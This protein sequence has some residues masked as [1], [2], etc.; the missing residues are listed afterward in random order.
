VK[1]FTS[2]KDIK[3]QLH[4]ELKC[5]P[6]RMQLYHSVGAKGLANQSTLHDL[7]IIQAGGVLYL[8]LVFSTNPQF[9][10]LP[11]KDMCVD[12]QC[13]EM[14]N[15]VRLGLRSGH[16]PAKTDML[17]CTG[18][19]Y[20]LKGG[21][22]TPVA[23]FKPSDEE[24][25]MP[26]NPKGYAGNGD[27][28]LRPYFRPGEGYLRETASYILDKDHF[29][30]VPPTV[31]VHCE[32]DAFHYPRSQTG[33]KT[34]F[35]K[36][37]SLQRF[38]PSS[39]TFED[40]GHSLV[41]VLE[42]QKIALLDMRLL[43][44]DRNA[45][46]ILALRKSPAARAVPRRY[47]R[48]SSLGT[49]SECYEEEREEISMDDFL[50]AEL[51]ASHTSR[52]SDQYTLVPI[53]HGYCLPSHLHIDEYDWAW[54]HC[55]HVA[56]E[57]QPEIKAYVNG[58]DIDQLLADLT[59]QVPVSEDCLYLL[60]VAHAVIKEGIN[61]GLSLRDI[62]G[63]IARTEEDV[64]SALE[65]A[66]AAAEDNALR[67]I[68][69]RSGRR[70]TIA[71]SPSFTKNSAEAADPS[72]GGIRLSALLVPPRAPRSTDVGS[73]PPVIVKQRA[74]GS[75]RSTGAS[76][77]P[78][79]I[80]AVKRIS[81][82][83]P[84]GAL[85][86]GEESDGYSI[87]STS[88][89]AK[90]ARTCNGGRDGEG[91]RRSAP[92]LHSAPDLSPRSAEKASALVRPFPLRSTP[93]R[94]RRVVS[95]ELNLEALGR[96]SPCTVPAPPSVG[97][98]YT[99]SSNSRSPIP[100]RPEPFFPVG[101][102]AAPVGC[103]E[104]DRVRI[105]Y[106]STENIQKLQSSPVVSSAK[107]GDF[108]LREASS[109]GRSQLDSGA[110]PGQ[111]PSVGGGDAGFGDY[112]MKDLTLPPASGP[113]ALRMELPLMA[114]QS[115]SAASSPHCSRSPSSAFN[116]HQPRA[117][118]RDGVSPTVSTEKLTAV[119]P[120]VSV[121]TASTK[122]LPRAF[123][124]TQSVGSSGSGGSGSSSRSNLQ[125]IGAAVRPRPG[126]P[127]F[128][129]QSFDDDVLRHRHRRT[130]SGSQGP[131]RGAGQGGTT[132]QADSAQ[133]RLEAPVNA[134]CLSPV[135]SVAVS[136][137]SPGLREQGAADLARAFVQEYPVMAA[138][139]FGSDSDFTSNSAGTSYESS[140]AAESPKASPKVPL[141]A[142]KSF[143]DDDGG[144][145]TAESS[146][147]HSDKVRVE[148]PVR[149]DSRYST[150]RAV[151]P[152]DGDTA[153]GSLCDAPLLLSVPLKGEQNQ[154]G[155]VRCPPPAADRECSS[156]VELWGTDTEGD[157]DD[158]S[159]LPIKAHGVVHSVMKPRA[160]D[161]GTEP[162][163]P[164]GLLSVP[165]QLSRV[166][167]FAAFDSPPLYDLAKSERQ[168]TRLRQER[169][170]ANAK[171]PEFQ[172]LRMLFSKE[173]VA[174]VVAKAGRVK[175]AT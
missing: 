60:R 88:G 31:M 38:V 80:G 47:S 32:H 105:G 45:S 156:S 76:S 41:G 111:S 51:A 67:T 144:T 149:N 57:V 104:T 101:A 42:L 35:P 24:Q 109:A 99:L 89:G 48:S 1:C 58:L 143:Q 93:D 20:F 127:L 131:G 7:G 61:A 108:W 148:V 114:L 100:T 17:D 168:L 53:D 62:A 141:L 120:A 33:Q 172:Q 171:T 64:P 84:S 82:P 2:I 25:G 34:L 15:D 96:A 169:R 10:L 29:C 97:S 49:A 54:F 22:N 8:G 165:V 167:S 68:E 151:A 71:N 158:L 52:Y 28:G 132:E 130:S 36:L 126:D 78:Q 175:A 133:N 116:L 98:S 39:D 145:T 139:L 56:V 147:V 74:V 154:F 87:H 164:G 153:A 70:G 110:R 124:S 121:G 94:P 81:P 14:M 122:L 4:K 113:D 136:P 69:S 159:P 150:R 37:G 155:T 160:A 163:S 12:E 65:N 43:N 50:D 9:M 119:A 91:E 3:D 83:T 123:N 170:K 161:P 6:S 129:L 26:N 79:R 135:V 55:P 27:C 59:R 174:A 40:I 106:L 157:F 107:V 134:P 115:S 21:T 137:T 63:L 117:G 16:L 46:N 23:V 128:T 13:E 95:S 11:A 5:P 90:Q 140:W 86:E 152:D 103:A 173:M 166:A 142:R 44:C 66:I 19:V 162:P 112:F 138:S 118:S 75:P 77:P 73:P 72:T 125:G 146:L 30:G 92:P 85:S 102:R 18:G